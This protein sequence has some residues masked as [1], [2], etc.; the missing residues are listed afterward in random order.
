MKKMLV[1]NF[2]SILKKII[3]ALTHNVSLFLCEYYVKF[4]EKKKLKGNFQCVFVQFLF[5]FAM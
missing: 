2:M 5:L 3:K 4:S 1:L